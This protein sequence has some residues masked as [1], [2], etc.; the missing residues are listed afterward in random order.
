MELFTAF[1]LVI[2]YVFIVVTSVVVIALYA[3]LASK[4]LNRTLFNVAKSAENIKWTIAFNLWREKQKPKD[5]SN[6][7]SES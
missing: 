2:G 7:E 6:K 5:E 4:L 3:N 1:A